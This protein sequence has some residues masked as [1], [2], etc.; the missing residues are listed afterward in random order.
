[1][2]A[3]ATGTLFGRVPC[4][5]LEDGRRVI[6]QSGLLAEIRKNPEKSCSHEPETRTTSLSQFLERLPPEFTAFLARTE[7]SPIEFTSQDGRGEAI[8]GYSAKCFVDVC[9]AYQSAFLADKLHRKQ[10]ALA[11]NAMA[12]LSSLATVGI[13]ALI[14]EATGYQKV[15]SE[16]ALELRMAKLL[17]LEAGRWEKCFPQSLVR[18]LAPLYGI[19]YVSGSY[20]KALHRPFGDIYDIILGPDAAAEMRRRNVNPDALCHHQYLQSEAHRGVSFDLEIAEAIARTSG[21]RKDFWR[22]M[23]THFNRIPL[24]LSF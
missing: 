15:R 21:S 7:N 12:I 5:V 19:A 20:P 6:S 13:E 4:Y 2:K 8:L 22:R 17:R 3:I 16:S 11:R 9:R 18:A 10:I 24:Q 14:D 23:R 1:M